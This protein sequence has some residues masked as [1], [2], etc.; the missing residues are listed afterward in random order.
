M[1]KYIERILI[2]PYNRPAWF[3]FAFSGCFKNNIGKCGEL[4]GRASSNKTM[5]I[6]LFYAVI[7]IA[8]VLL[9]FFGQSEQAEAQLGMKISPVRFEEIAD[10][11]KTIR[12]E[13]KVTNNTG[14]KNTFYVYLRDFRAEGETGQAKLIPP[15]TVTDYSLAAWIDITGEGLELEV[16]E[17]T[18]IPYAITIPADA[19]PGGYYGAILIG[20][21][22]PRLMLESEERGAGMTVAQQTGSL[23]LLQVRGDVVEEARVREFTV[24]KNVYGTPFETKFLLRI[25]NLG[26]VHIKPKGMISIKNMF[27]KEVTVFRVNDLD[28]NVLPNSI[29]RFEE[30]W[31][32]SN[33]FGRYTASCGLTFGTAADL[34][35]AGKQSLFAET[36]FWIVPWRIIIP[37]LI[38]A[39]FLSALAILLLRLYRNQAIRKAMAQAGLGHVRYVKK[40]E[41][42]SPALHF[43]LILLV[44]FIMMFLAVGSFYLIFFA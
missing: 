23:I 30:K 17:T 3:Y 12:N 2:I 19:G 26:N 14:G 1:L 35:G 38:G 29:R 41:G 21:L 16:G 13:I 31:A 32:G 36:T 40:F 11:G 39:I 24:D 20:T 15:G 18:A 22:P 8:F 5:K 28:A 25:E 37:G 44:V 43:S 34:G 10:P 6:K 33:G 42:P 4:L 7:F 27:G 9:I